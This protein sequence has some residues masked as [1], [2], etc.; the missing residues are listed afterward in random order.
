L[1]KDFG[2]NFETQNALL[3]VAARNKL[4]LGDVNFRGPLA[5]L[6]KLDSQMQELLQAT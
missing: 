6:N 3:A 2:R 1:P 4:G 5:F